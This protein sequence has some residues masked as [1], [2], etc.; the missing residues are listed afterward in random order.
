[1]KQITKTP[2]IIAKMKASFGPDINVESLAVYESIALNTLPLRKSSGLFKGAR[3]TAATLSLIAQSINKESAP[4]QSQ[5][6]TSVLP[7]GRMF[8][9]EVVDGDELRSLW[10]CTDPALQAGIDAGTIDQTSV[11]FLPAKINCSACGFDYKPESAWENRYTLTCDDGHVLGEDGCFAWLDGCETF[12]EYSL[13]GKGAANGARIV[14]PSEAKLS[15]NEKFRLAASSSADGFGVVRLTA[16]PKDTDSVDIAPLMASLEAANNSKLDL[17]VKLAAAETAKTAAEAL[18]AAAEARAVA[19]E[20]AL[21]AATD[22]PA[23]AE[24][25][26][27][28][29]ATIVALKAEALMVLTAVGKP[30]EAV[31]ET[32]TDL[33]AQIAEHRAN[34]AAYV[35]IGGVSLNT[36][37]T[38][39]APLRLAATAFTTRK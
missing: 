4:L 36:D 22:A 17:T 34:L 39:E 10:T 33:L 19:A 6:D 18:V 25:Q 35:P 32:V 28:Q 2:D 37:K 3:V 16:T 7:Q 38:D 31:K 27:E 30:S 8:Y 13:V 15:N 26:A 9:A 14:G 24:L 20:A 21:A 5:H 23:L 29:A 1:M 11:S 12:L